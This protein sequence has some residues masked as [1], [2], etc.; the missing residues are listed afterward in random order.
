MRN[1]SDQKQ[2]AKLVVSFKKKVKPSGH[3]NESSAYG[4]L[5]IGS[6]CCLLKDEEKKTMFSGDLQIL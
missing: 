2:F 5:H 4:Q 6:K 3:P 1:N